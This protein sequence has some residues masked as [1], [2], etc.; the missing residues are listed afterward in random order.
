MASGGGGEGKEGDWEG[1]VM[2]VEDREE[3]V[4]HG[5]RTVKGVIRERRRV[6]LRRWRVAMVCD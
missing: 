1:L 5:G 3:K 6:R 2:E 4:M